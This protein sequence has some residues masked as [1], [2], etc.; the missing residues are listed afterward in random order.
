M[1]TV[2]RKLFIYDTTVDVTV[3]YDNVSGA[4]STIS[5]R[6][7]A[8]AGTMEATLSDPANGAIIFGPATRTFGTGTVTQSINSLSM[9]SA[10]VSKFA[11]DGW[12]LPFNYRFSWSSA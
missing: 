6:N 9:V 2:N 10:P 12:A 11:P 1:A 5:L 4:M 8:A 7:D 3:A